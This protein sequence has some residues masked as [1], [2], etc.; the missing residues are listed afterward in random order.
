M[1]K[2]QT[3]EDKYPNITRF[4]EEQGCI[5]VGYDEDT[6]IYAFVKAYDAGGT[7]YE[8]KREYKSMED[9]FQDLE[10]NIK[11]YLEDLGI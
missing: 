2:N 10:E 8:G 3:F 9:A 6:P 1:A 7:V 11:A 4:V 5:E